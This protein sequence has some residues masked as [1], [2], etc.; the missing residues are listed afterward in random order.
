[1]IHLCSRLGSDNV[2][3]L[4]IADMISREVTRQSRG[5]NLNGICRGHPTA[6]WCDLG[7]FIK[8]MILLGL[9][10]IDGVDIALGL[11]FLRP[12]EFNSLWR[13]SK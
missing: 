4:F 7:M 13:N 9:C 8:N 10:I 6:F 12:Y 11:Q 3:T 5:F 2:I 1:M